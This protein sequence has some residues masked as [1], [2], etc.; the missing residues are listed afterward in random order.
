MHIKRN[1]IPKFWPIP[2][3]GNKY[4]AV[5]DHNQNESI[6]LSIVMRD[7]F[8]LVR[9]KKELIKTLNEK[10]IKI[11]NKIINETN[12]PISLFDV[13]KIESAKKSYRASLSE[14]KKII[15]EEINDK[16]SKSKVY[17]VLNKK[18]LGTDKTQL[19]LMFGKNILTKEK[20]NVG[21]SVLI[22][23]E[24]NKIEKVIPLE[25]GRDA[26]V[27]EGRH[28]GKQGKIE[29]IIV[30][31]DKRLAKIIQKDGK[32]NVWIKNLIIIK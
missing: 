22:S 12:Y 16:D 18:I 2:K 24:N 3:K 14:H 7:I 32:I 29:D 15:F 4:V 13:I 10:Q 11:N 17:K 20:V 27:I 23:I 30:R 9:N 31:G 5:P 6:P 25:K 26:F 1:N 8:K 28:A 19:N 21:D